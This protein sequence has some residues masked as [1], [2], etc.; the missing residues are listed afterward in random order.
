[1]VGAVQAL[2]VPDGMVYAVGDNPD[3]SIDSRVWGCVP[4]GELARG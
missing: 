1:M 4:R 2:T 3:V